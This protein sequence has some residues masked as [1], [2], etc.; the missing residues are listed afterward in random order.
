MIGSGRVGADGLGQGTCPG[1]VPTI[2]FPRG[3]V[4]TSEPNRRA[5]LISLLRGL[6]NETAPGWDQARARVWARIEAALL[7]TERGKLVHILAERGR[8]DVS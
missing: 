8:G 1:P 5:V 7:F 2:T 4:V 6:G 3:A